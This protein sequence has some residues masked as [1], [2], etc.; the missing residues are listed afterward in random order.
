MSVRC[1]VCREPIVG[2]AILQATR[3]MHRGYMRLC[4]GCEGDRKD[5]EPCARCGRAIEGVVM[6]VRLTS[7]DARDYHQACYAYE[8]SA[9]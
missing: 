9:P 6:Q 7:G 8:R 3:A 2:V 4:A 5:T 1:D